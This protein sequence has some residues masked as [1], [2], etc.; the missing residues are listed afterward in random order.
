MGKPWTGDYVFSS[1]DLIEDLTHNYF[2]ETGARSGKLR[3]YEMVEHPAARALTGYLLVRGGVH[4]VAYAR[5]LENLTG[6]DLTKLFPSPN[7]PTEKIPG[8]P[9]RTSTRAAHEALPLLAERL[10]RAGGGLQR[11]A[12]G[13]G[14]GARGRGRHARG[15]PVDGPPAAA[16]G[17]RAGLRARGHRGDRRKLREA[18]GLPKEPTGVVGNDPSGV[19]G[20]VKEKLSSQ[21]VA[22]P[23]AAGLDDGGGGERT[24]PEAGPAR[25]PRPVG[26]VSCTGRM[27]RYLEILRSPHVARC[28]PRRCWRGCRSASTGS[29]S[30]C[31]SSAETGSF[32]AAGA[33][34][35]ALALGTGLAAPLAARLIDALGARMLLVLAGGPRRR[36][37]A[38]IGAGAARAPGRRPLVAAAFVAGAAFPP[39]SSVRARAVPAA[40]RRPARAAAGRV[41]AGLRADGA[42]FTV[43][44]LLTAALVVAVRAGRGAPRLGRRRARRARSRSSP[45]CPPDGPR[46]GSAPAAGWA[47]SPR[48]G[49]GPSSPRCSRSASRSARSR[50]RSRRSP[51]T[52]AG[53][54]WRAC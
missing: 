34:A 15:L 22:A 8:V 31:S 29:P 20:K 26:F 18:A 48:R 7:I 17:V 44:P 14:R 4:Q 33:A 6:A 2:L 43:G 12:P 10:P 52:R 45:R 23:P 27:R 38:L 46:C 49:S 32:G 3:V 40:V 50:S 28:S 54:S 42:I 51:T 37:L 35:G 36:L 19:V 53:R 13:D 21:G 1:G 24:F 30:C 41:R 11:P 5:A 16:G 47:R 9:S 25:A 39:A